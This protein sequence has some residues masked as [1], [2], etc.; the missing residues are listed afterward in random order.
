MPPQTQ[1][2]GPLTERYDMIR[3]ADCTFA[4]PDRPAARALRLRSVSMSP[5]A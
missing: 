4:E 2:S 3:F 5:A 1:L